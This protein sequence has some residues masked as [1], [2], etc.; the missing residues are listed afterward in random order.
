MPLILEKQSES[1]WLNPTL[2][3]E[4]LNDLMHPYG[5]KEME[6]FSVSNSI[7]QVR[8]ERNVPETLQ[9]VSYPELVHL[10]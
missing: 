6:A 9:E 1:L 7:N 10:P 5:M 8:N 3:R 2:G 4:E